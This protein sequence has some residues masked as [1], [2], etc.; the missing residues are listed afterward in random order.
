MDLQPDSEIHREPYAASRQPSLSATPPGSPVVQSGLDERQRILA[1]WNATRYHYPVV[2]LL[3]TLFE[4]R[5]ADTPDALAVV[6]EGQALTYAAL[7]RS[8]SS[9]A[10]LLQRAGVGPE[11]FVAVYLERSLEMVGAFLAIFKAGGACV[12]LDVATPPERLAFLLRDCAPAVVVTQA[13]MR[14]RLPSEYRERAIV[15]DDLPADA[16]DS[17]APLPW[18]GHPLQAANLLYTSGSTGRPK[19]VVNTHAGLHNRLFWMQDRYRL[20]RSDRVLQ[21]T[22]YSFDVSLWE[23]MWPLQIGA[24]LV[25]A[26]SEGHKD[27]AYLAQLIREQ[28][29]TVAHFVP[30]MLHIFLDEPGLT[31]CATLRAIFCSGEVL[32]AELQRR[33]FARLDAELHNLY[34]PTEAAIDVTAWACRRDSVARTV[35]IGSPIYNTQII[36]LDQH[37]AFV[38][39][40]VHG[41]LYI[42]GMGLARGYYR[43]PDLTAACFLPHPGSPEPGERLYKTGDLACE[44]PENTFEYKGRLDHQ[45]KLRGQRIELGEIE[46]A[47]EH[48][49]GVR[50]CLVQ[51]QTFAAND[52]RLVAYL[53]PAGEP[54][55]ARKELLGF[56]RLSLPAYMLPSV[57]VYLEAWPLLS[58]GKINRHALPSAT[59]PRPGGARGPAIAAAPSPGE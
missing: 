41:D 9:L 45:V 23:I 2:P 44:Q 30:S 21:K 32:S 40:G 15:L 39:Q 4:Q 28:S 57:F 24:T 7:N 17:S 47:L 11:I 43:R 36:V 16:E 35:P 49:P 58:N 22:P 31:R 52:Q 6:S 1:A 18:Q 12:P 56:L 48:H 27:S 37:G 42:G 19:G 54:R 53:I 46:I 3:H 50:S 5:A 8:A 26:R 29:I 20:Q 34:G 33:C 55:P 25:L 13:Q 14:D 51:V 10:R 59:A 38:P